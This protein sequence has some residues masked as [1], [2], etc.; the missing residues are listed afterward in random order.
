[1]KIYCSFLALLGELDNVNWDSAFF[2]EPLSWSLDPQR[3]EILFL[4]GD[5]ELED[6]VPG[7]HLP[8]IANSKGMR[9]LFDTETL[10]D[11]VNAERERNAAASVEDIVFAVN[12]YREKDEFYDPMK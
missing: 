7:T 11:I 1:M 3:A 4:E 6:L 9:Q 12:F 2:I 5:D 8:K 10:R